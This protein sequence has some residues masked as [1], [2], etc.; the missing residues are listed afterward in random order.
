MAF[1]GLGVVGGFDGFGVRVA[2]DTEDV[3]GRLGVLPVARLGEKRPHGG[4]IG[5][6]LG[7]Q[8][9]GVV[10]CGGYSWLGYAGDGE[11]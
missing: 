5:G 6:G 7:E 4:R 3:V 8:I 11:W 9:V 10:R 2:T 1:L